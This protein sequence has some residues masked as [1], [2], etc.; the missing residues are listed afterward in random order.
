MLRNPIIMFKARI[1][2]SLYHRFAFQPKTNGE[3]WIAKR[4]HNF[5]TTS[6]KKICDLP[7]L[8]QAILR[9]ACV[10]KFRSNRVEPDS[11][12]GK[13]KEKI[14]DN[15]SF[16]V[17]YTIVVQP[18]WSNVRWV[19]KAIRMLSYKLVRPVCLVVP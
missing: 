14:L 4:M 12:E 8:N 15:F 2:T 13:K 3:S 18:F 5:K 9:I 17:R 16:S 10:G 1:R 7:R 6:L 19:P 11:K